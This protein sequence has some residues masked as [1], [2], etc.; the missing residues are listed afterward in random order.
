MGCYC[1]CIK[2]GCINPKIYTNGFCDL[3][4][5]E[6]MDDKIEYHKFKME[7]Q[8]LEYYRKND[9]GFYLYMMQASDRANIIK[10]KE[11]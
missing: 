2:S 4:F 10:D 5:K 1:R 7:E 3:H 11:Q 6:D 8:E 9:Y